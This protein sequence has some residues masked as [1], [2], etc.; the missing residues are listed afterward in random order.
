MLIFLNIPQTYKK[1]STE[2][3]GMKFLRKMTLEWLEQNNTFTDLA[4]LRTVLMAFEIVL[5]SLVVLVL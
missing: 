2:N 3:L 1:N 5:L 4:S